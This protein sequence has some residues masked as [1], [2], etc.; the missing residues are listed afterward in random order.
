MMPTGISIGATTV[1]PTASHATRNVPPARTENGA[2]RAVSRPE[3]DP[4]D[5]RHH[6]PD[7]ADRPARRDDAAD[8]QRRGGENELLDRADRDA[9]RRRRFLADDQQIEL[10]RNREQDRD[11]DDRKRQH[12]DDRNEADDL[13]PAKQPAANPK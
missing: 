9:S 8:H 3:D 6:E 5:V 10:A 1:R 11:A 4:P 13:E 7:E 2:E 12:V